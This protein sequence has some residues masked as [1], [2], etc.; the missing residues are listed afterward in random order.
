MSDVDKF[1]IH[2]AL[3]RCHVIC[4]NIDDH[5][6]T[7][8]AVEKYAYIREK[9]L[10]GQ[11]LIASAYQELGALS[12]E[13]EPRDSGDNKKRVPVGRCEKCGKLH[14]LH[15]SLNKCCA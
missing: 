8:P 9:I 1:H 7:H 2:E 10:N 15:I 14:F 12:I 6:L 5:L 3:D 11:S 4:S 13:D